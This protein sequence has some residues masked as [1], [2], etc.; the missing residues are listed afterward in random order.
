MKRIASSLI[1]FIALTGGG[2]YA[3]DVA[4]LAPE[5]KTPMS[6]TQDLLMTSVL[7]VATAPARVKAAH[8]L[9]TGTVL[10]ASDLVIEGDV[11]NDTSSPLD[12]FVG[13]EIKRTVYAGKILSANDVGPPTLVARNAIVTLEFARGPLLIT[14]EGRALDSG[15]AGERIR[16]M[17]LSSK[18][19]LT[20]TVTGPNKAMTR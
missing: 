4:A 3:Q 2:A 12:L 5:R 9:R 17:N 19:I 14:T 1:G 13:M 18:T 10:H 20:A 11:H 16:I 6:A 8:T 15:A 7:P